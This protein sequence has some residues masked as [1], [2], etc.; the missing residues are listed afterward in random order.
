MGGSE[1]N[2]AGP[3][4]DL[5]LGWLGHRPHTAAELRK[6]L[7]EHGLDPGEIDETLAGLARQGQVDDRRLALFYLLTRSGRLGHGPAR[8]AKELEE[9]G[10][11]AE[12]IR[13]AWEE[14]V[15]D[16]GL[17]PVRLLDRALAKRLPGG[18][19]DRTAARRVYNALLRAG[20]EAHAV[21]QAL[22]TRLDEEVAGFD[23]PDTEPRT[24]RPFIPETRDE[25]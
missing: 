20:F 18:R 10:V 17:D 15:R 21:R 22:I 11:A 7:A 19:I 5:A 2:H 6:R 9:R 25:R 3:A 24:T 8:L 12:T 14:A 1:P 23:E 13:D 16:H 4:V